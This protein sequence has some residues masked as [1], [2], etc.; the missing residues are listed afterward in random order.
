M[1]DY[2]VLLAYSSFG[3][4]HE[5]A[6]RA[7]GEVFEQ[8][9]W[10]TRYVDFL[11]EV[12]AA[13]RFV[14][15]DAYLE[16]IKILPE[17]YELAFQHT[18]TLDL[19]E[20]DQTSRV[21][22]NVGYRRLRE[23]ALMEAPDAI[24]STNIW[25]TLALSKVKQ[26]R[27]QGTPLINC[28]TDYVLQTL[29]MARGV[30]WH[31][32]ASEQ[33]AATFLASHRRVHQPIYPFGIPIHPLFAVHRSQRE[34]RSVLGIAQDAH[35]AVVMGGGLGLG[36]ILETCDTLTSRPFGE[37]VTVAALCGDNTDVQ[38]QIGSL[39]IARSA[40]HTIIPV[41]WTD[42][43]AAY[44]QAAD[45]LITK[46]GGVTIAEAA[47]VGVPLVIYQP[48]PGQETVNSRFLTQHEAAYAA[49]DTNQLLRASDELMFTARGTDVAGNLRRLGK[50]NASRDIVT[51]ICRDVCRPAPP[52]ESA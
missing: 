47:A 45:L 4:G 50:P 34:A 28:F 16:L 22:A 15:R 11:D 35:L 48:L 38:N 9:G 17:A 52:E 25:P 42:E 23:L 1:A 19:K 30:N 14:M 2:K 13:M 10:A 37:P 46:A 32:A 43:I 36:H 29:Y 49:E 41:G 31:V 51:R 5:Q 12:P 24:V 33:I 21:L 44:M 8:R 3:A 18:V 26:H 6:A 40:S 20:A 27:L 7:L 39:A